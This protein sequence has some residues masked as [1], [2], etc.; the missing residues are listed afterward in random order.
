MEYSRHY[1]FPPRFLGEEYIMEFWGLV[2][3]TN[4][5]PVISIPE[6]SFSSVENTVFVNGWAQIIV[7]NPHF[8]EFCIA[9]YGADSSAFLQDQ[10]HDDIILE[11][12]IEKEFSGLTK[13]YY[14]GGYSLWP[15]GDSQITIKTPDEIAVT[16]LSED[17]I[18]G[19]QCMKMLEEGKI[20][21]PK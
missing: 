18:S 16:F 4:C 12:T 5:A 1:A 2:F 19:T 11:K 10:F 9:L 7:K 8:I 20:I 14:F 15:R 6:L 3:H 17:C 21:F 13:E